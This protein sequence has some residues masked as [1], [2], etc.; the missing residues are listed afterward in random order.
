MRRSARVEISQLRSQ[1]TGPRGAADEAKNSD[2]IA[3]LKAQLADLREESTRQRKVIA[4]YKSSK[5]AEGN[6]L[7]HW[8]NEAT[9]LDETCKFV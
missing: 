7:S 4:S 9:Q 5:T 6:S 3:S 2:V 8:K 1:L